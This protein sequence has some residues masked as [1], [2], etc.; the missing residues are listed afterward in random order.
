[1]SDNI[2]IPNTTAKSMFKLMKSLAI[3]PKTR[4]QIKTAM[5]LKKAP[6]DTIIGATKLGF[7]K[8]DGTKLKLSNEYKNV[9]KYDEKHP[10][11]KKAF[12]NAFTQYQP[13][14]LFIKIIKIYN[15]KIKKENVGKLL[16]AE[17]NADWKISSETQY[18]NKLINWGE[19]CGILLNENGFIKLHPQYMSDSSSIENGDIDLKIIFNRYLYDKYCENDLNKIHKNL[20]KYEADLSESKKSGEKFEKIVSSYL[21]LLG[22]STRKVTGV[23]E[24]KMGVSYT[25]NDGGGDLGLFIHSPLYYQ[26]KNYK[27]ISVACELKEKKTG[28]PKKSLDQVR[29]FS[30]QMKRLFPDYKIFRIVISQSTSYEPVYARKNAEPNIVHVPFKVIKNLFEIQKNRFDDNKE[31]ITPIQLI[32]ILDYAI[33][34]GNLEITVE[35][36]NE[37]INHIH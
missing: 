7:I 26:G 20:K 28:A 3:G 1:M 34:D 35:Y 23:K 16:K 33:K 9:V 27:G 19:F 6:Y 18:V 14:K 8:S 24:K 36:V 21:R 31:L 17:L 30:E 37:I 22:F 4:D 2:S 29:T 12:E 10:H 25:P 5:N 32:N 15:G 11:V 13:F